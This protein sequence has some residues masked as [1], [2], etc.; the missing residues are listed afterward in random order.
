MA[1]VPVACEMCGSREWI[2]VELLNAIESGVHLA[3]VG[4]SDVIP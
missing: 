2:V 3:E 4:I 1:A